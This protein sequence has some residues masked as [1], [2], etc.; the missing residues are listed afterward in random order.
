MQAP[1]CRNPTSAL[2]GAPV[3]EP[4]TT[5]LRLITIHRRMSSINATDTNISTAFIANVQGEA[6]DPLDRG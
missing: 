2:S 4:T 5:G 6:Y 1:A 3:G